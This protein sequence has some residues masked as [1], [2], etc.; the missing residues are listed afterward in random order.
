MRIRLTETA[1]DELEEILSYIAADNLAS[2]GRV[3]AAVERTLNWIV[4]ELSRFVAA[5]VQWICGHK[6][7]DRFVASGLVGELAVVRW[8]ASG[9][10]EGWRL[11]RVTSSGI[12]QGWKV[13]RS[14]ASGVVGIRFV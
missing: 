6:Y 7:V 1:R 4:A 12:V 14:A 2:A 8:A 10:V 3:A 13:L 11:D 5:D 9:L